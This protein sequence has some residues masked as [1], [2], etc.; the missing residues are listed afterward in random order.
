MWYSRGGQVGYDRGEDGA[1]KAYSYS[2]EG[3]I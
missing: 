1:G 3:K 2:R